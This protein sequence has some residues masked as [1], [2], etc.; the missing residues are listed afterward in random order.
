MREIP[1]H[2]ED[3]VDTELLH[4]DEAHAVYDAVGLVLVP[5]EV[6]EGRPF[7]QSNPMPP[8]SNKNEQ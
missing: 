3:L 7:T 5:L 1:V 8:R 4:H 6:L 2:R